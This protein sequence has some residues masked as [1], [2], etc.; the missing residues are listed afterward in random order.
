[1]I[2]FTDDDTSPS[3]QWV[4]AACAFLEVN[5]EY[6]GVEG[7]TVSPP[8][9]PLYQHSVENHLP[10][11][12]WTC[13]VGYR[14][15]ALKRLGGFSEVFRFPHC[16]DLDLGFRA[17]RHGPIGFANEMRVLHHPS[18]VSM[19]D[20]ILRG[21]YAA[22]EI[23]LFQRHPDRYRSKTPTRLLPMRKRLNRIRAALRREGFSIALAPRRLARF[24]GAAAGQLGIVLA[25]SLKTTTR[26]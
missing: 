8:Y 13:N 4:D 16:E 23:Y 15:E 7:P 26:R 19:R 18:D 22:S 5:P 10:G 21:R 12:Y 25:T 11:A 3:P 1:V 6:V 17:L 20:M 24:V 9:D 14:R 2:L